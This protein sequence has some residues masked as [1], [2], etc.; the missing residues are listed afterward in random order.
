MRLIAGLLCASAL[1]GYAPGSV[2]ADSSIYNDA[3]TGFSFS[4]STVAYQI[5]QTIA[6]RIATPNPVP[7]GAYD[8][9]I[10]LAAPYAVGWAGIA[11]GGRMINC[12]LTV[13]WANGQS[14]TVSS[15][16]ATQHSTP[17]TYTGASYQLLKRGTHTN[18]TH[19]QYTVKCIGCTSFSGTTL[20]ARGTNR[21]AFA[22]AASKPSSPSSNTSS[23]PV[24]DVT[25]Y[26]TH[27]FSQSGN[28]QFDT[29]VQ[30]NA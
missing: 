11:W 23:F 6:V 15:R 24:H 30:R 28:T 21:L 18:G 1:L 26:W 5:G 16:Y 17:T 29:L 13:G 19:W 2:A 27:D 20:N 25:G 9:V 14:A 3:E 8:I 12:P 10:Q 4:Q 7:S 22:Q